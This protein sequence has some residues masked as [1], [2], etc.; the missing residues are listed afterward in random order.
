MKSVLVDILVLLVLF[1]INAFFALAEMAIVSSRKARLQH[2]VNRGDR[3]ARLALQLANA[4]SL[5]LSSVQIGISLVAILSGAFGG[6][7]LSQHLAHALR[8][9][10][11]LA[12]Y[13]EP[14]SFLVVVVLITYFSLVIGELVPK[15]VALNN[16]EHFAMAVAAPMH[17]MTRIFSPL[18]SLLSASSNMVMKL[19]GL[20]RHPEPPVSDEEIKVLFEEGVSAGVFE[21]Q[22]KEIVER[23]FR[24]SD[25]CV[26]AIMTLRT[27][28]AWLESQASPDEVARTIAEHAHS[29][30]P[31]CAEDIDHVV[32]VV[33]ARDIVARVVQ[34][35]PV[36]LN[37]VMR[38]PLIFPEG[39]HAL[40]AIDLLRQ[41]GTHIAIIIN[42]YGGTEGLLT[43]TD[44]IE[45]LIGDVVSP[46]E[47][48][49]VVQ[50][51][52]GSLLVDGLLPVDDVKALLQ[53]NE[54][55]LEAE[56]HYQTLAGFVMTYL[57]RVPRTGDAFVWDG[58]HFEIVDMDGNRIDRVL[59]S[60]NPPQNGAAAQAA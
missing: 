24:L 21:R 51:P 33:L 38:P 17:A 13:R 3:R 57:G 4:P 2:L 27:E 35:Q 44:I 1:L 56:T 46:A 28:I 15:R 49:D 54:L 20:R 11:W 12:P 48:P 60:P 6:A 22:E 47:E 34:G 36:W 31:V 50:R 55:P 32:G 10:P 59:I 8:D 26:N 18:V 19:L 9:V 14:I 5:F 42:E 7:I 53:R 25:R 30:Y 41:H 23:M 43:L 40:R 37:E 39:T 29:A 45:S 16:P 52:D 58:Y